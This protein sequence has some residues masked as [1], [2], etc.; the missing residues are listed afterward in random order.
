MCL[1]RA[2]TVT[3]VVIVLLFALLIG[4]FLVPVPPLEGT[5]PP[6]S[7]ADA[8]SR[9]VRVGAIEV[10]YRE[11][12][13]GDPTIVLLHGFGASTFTWREVMNPLAARH[14]VVAYDRP[15]FG[16]TER[17]LEWTGTNPYSG[18][19][20]VE[21]AAGLLDALGADT[22]ILIGNSAGGRVA[23]DF[24]LALPERVR[25]LVL[26]S[27]ALGQRR[28]GSLRAVLRPLLQT[29]QLGH[30]GPRFVRTIERSG[31]ETIAR[32]WHRPEL[33]TE[34]VLAGY[35]LPLQA[36]HWDRA[37]FELTRAP[38]GP[39]PAA[40]LDGLGG[41][42]TLVVTGDDDRIVPTAAT[43]T[44]ATR[45]PRATLEILPACGHLPQEECPTEFLDVVTRFIESL[46]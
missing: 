7:L 10:H 16:L 39:D 21:L 28:G 22:A 20:Q 34:S 46:P 42:P 11:Q 8:D 17:P 2:R 3:R 33:V 23:V 37:L 4:P 14:R 13:A 12:G 44:L 9:F 24:A 5:V 27:P 32:A 40:R 19:A 31:A 35:R 41:V 15:A 36:E 43:V 30:L 29:P 1:V 6:R 38:R 45:I 26:V 18:P 25:G